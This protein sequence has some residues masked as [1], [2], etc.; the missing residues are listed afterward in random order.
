MVLTL[1]ATTPMEDS[2]EDDSESLMEDF[3]YTLVEEAAGT[4]SGYA[5][6]S[7]M[8]EAAGPSGTRNLLVMLAFLMPMIQMEKLKLAQNDAK[9]DARAARRGG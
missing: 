3:G 9:C 1:I 4:S 8:E 5:A 7:R 6:G 2:L